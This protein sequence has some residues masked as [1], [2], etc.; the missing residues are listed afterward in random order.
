MTRFFFNL[1]L[2]VTP[3]AQITCYMVCCL[4]IAEP[5][6]CP[7]LQI[8]RNLRGIEKSQ[9]RTDISSM[10]CCR[11]PSTVDDFNSQLRSVLDV[12]APAARREVTQRKSAPWYSSVAP[13]LR[14]LRK[15]RRRAERQWQAS[16]LTV[17]QQIMNSFKH[18]IT[19]LV[20]RAETGFYTSKVAVAKTCKELFRL[21]GSL[22]GK[23]SLSSSVCLPPTPSSASV[24][25]LLLLESCGNPWCH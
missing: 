17:H 16:G 4:D 5:P 18:Q 21:T 13:E 9:V 25:G 24:F 7:V 2:R 23:V 8:V 15:E 12:H 19:K 11:P 20:T 14:A 6:R 3:R 1:S 10:F 22:M